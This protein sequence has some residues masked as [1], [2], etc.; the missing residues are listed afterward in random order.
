MVGIILDVIVFAMI[1]LNVFIGYKKGLIK[2]AVSFIAVLASLII[3]IILYKPVSNLIIE[4]TD[5]DEKITQTIIES[6]TSKENEKEEI[7]ENDNKNYNEIMK[8]YLEDAATDAKDNVVES[9]A[10]TIA[11]KIINIIVLI[12]IFVICR[13]ILILLVLIAD[14]IAKLPLLKQ[15]NKA[16]GI[17]Y[18]LIKGLIWVYAILSVVF[19]IVY[20]TNNVSISGAIDKSIITK[21]MY[22]NN[23][24]LNIIF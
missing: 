4:K 17:V 15:I 16:G 18:G 23:M 21:L 8:K 5:F 12:V 24:I 11:I 10:P 3:A 22:D 1:L 14:T 6:A 20:M 2:L 19:L 9:A 13:L 7:N